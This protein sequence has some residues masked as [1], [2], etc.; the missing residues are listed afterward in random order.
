MFDI[1]RNSSSLFGFFSLVQVLYPP[2]HI[3]I[4]KLSLTK[5]K[6]EKEKEKKKNLDQTKKDKVPD[7][8]R[9]LRK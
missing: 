6:K 4:T 5:K 8:K 1:R 9:T 3:P 2:L 7:R